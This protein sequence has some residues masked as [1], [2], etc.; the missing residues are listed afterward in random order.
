VT[1]KRILGEDEAFQWDRAYVV[2]KEARE[3]LQ[4]V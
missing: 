1:L 3:A 4:Y 2:R